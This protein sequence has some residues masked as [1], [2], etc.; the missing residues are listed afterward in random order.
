MQQVELK[1]RSIL[2]QVT[3]LGR[4]LD[5]GQLDDYPPS[6]RFLNGRF[7]HAKLVDPVADDFQ[8]PADSIIRLITQGRNNIWNLIAIL[9]I[10]ANQTQ[11][12][13]GYLDFEDIEKI[14]ARLAEVDAGIF[15]QI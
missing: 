5:T 7:A 15:D 14:K 2:D 11:V 6:T 13:F 8:C 9:G 1:Q 12:A 3:C 4:I 10:V